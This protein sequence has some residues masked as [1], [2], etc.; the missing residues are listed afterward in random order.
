M[1][2]RKLAQSLFGAEIVIRPTVFSPF[3]LLDWDGNVTMVVSG[4]A[5]QTAVR[6]EQTR[7]TGRLGHGTLLQHMEGV[8]ISCM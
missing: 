7:C 4:K 3:G 2:I 5:I 1:P 6:A 8:W